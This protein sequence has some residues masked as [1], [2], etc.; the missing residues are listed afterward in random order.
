MMNAP[1][2]CRY[3]TGEHWPSR[4]IDELKADKKTLTEKIMSISKHMVCFTKQYCT[5]IIKLFLLPFITNV[6]TEY[7]YI[8]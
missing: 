3:E 5:D 7:R 2:I 1:N 6:Q 8:S 4:N